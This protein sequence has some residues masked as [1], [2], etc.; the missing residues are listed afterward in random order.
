MCIPKKVC[1]RT[2]ALVV[3]AFGGVIVSWVIFIAGGA[4]FL[5]LSNAGR[6]SP[7]EQ[8]TLN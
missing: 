7:K 5:F 3:E 8:S 1:A 4:V 6:S 2:R